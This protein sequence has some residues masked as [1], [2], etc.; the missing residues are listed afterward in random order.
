[1][2]GIHEE[3]GPVSF[4]EDGEEPE[5]HPEP[6]RQEVEW[7]EQKSFSEFV[8]RQVEDRAQRQQWLR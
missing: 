8:M 7:S 1:M 2:D 6:E 5:P 4:K 3:D